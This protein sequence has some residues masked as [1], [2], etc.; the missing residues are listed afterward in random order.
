MS[1]QVLWRELSVRTD[2]GRSRP[3][4]T[5]SALGAKPRGRQVCGRFKSL[6]QPFNALKRHGNLCAFEMI[7]AIN[8]NTSE[9]EVDGSLGM[10]RFHFVIPRM[11]NRP[12]KSTLPELKSTN[13]RIGYRLG[14]RGDWF[15]NRRFRN[16]GDASRPDARD[17]KPLTERLASEIESP[18]VTVACSIFNTYLNG[19]RSICSISP[20]LI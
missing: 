15:K 6:N 19:D 9:T 3:R 11:L 10:I 4:P 18:V 8:R 7:C 16:S 14:L 17:V 1:P 13:V 5:V 20:K 2:A 12:T